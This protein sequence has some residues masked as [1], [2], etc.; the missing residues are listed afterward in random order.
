VEE[1]E[2]RLKE[3]NS[4]A[5]HRKNDNINQP[6]PLELP[7]TIKHQPKNTHVGTHDSSHI[8]S[9]GWPC[10]TSM[11]GETFGPVKAHVPV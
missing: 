11:G 4:F 2:Q 7:G 1:L 10:R 3:L 8:C 9:R 6:D 5:T